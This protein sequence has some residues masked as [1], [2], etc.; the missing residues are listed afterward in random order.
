MLW[1][2]NGEKIEDIFICFDRMYE[3][4]GRT[5]T[6]WRH[7]PRLHSISRGKKNYL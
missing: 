1:L 5:D 3:R 2:P 6:A 7:R 4:D